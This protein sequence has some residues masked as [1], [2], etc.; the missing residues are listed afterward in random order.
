MHWIGQHW[1]ETCIASLVTFQLLIPRLAL[2]EEPGSGFVH[3]LS[4][5]PH[6]GLA[7]ALK[8]IHNIR[9]FFIF[10]E[11]EVDI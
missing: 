8:R 1:L 10:E 2:N 3:N 4:D 7:P 9:E 6:V 5:F 11:G